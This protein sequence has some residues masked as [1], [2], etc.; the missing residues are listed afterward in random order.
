MAIILKREKNHCM[1]AELN[2]A[3][4]C[5]AYCSYNIQQDY[6][7]DCTGKTGT[8]HSEVGREVTIPGRRVENYGEEQKT[9]DKKNP[10]YAGWKLEDFSKL[11]QGSKSP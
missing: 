11:R 1:F 9:T 7:A 3:G 10:S 5:V 4:R 6:K 2:S 8:H